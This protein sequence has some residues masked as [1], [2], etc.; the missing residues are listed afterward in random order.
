VVRAV[1][2]AGGRI[3]IAAGLFTY[4][5]GKTRF[6]QARAVPARHPDTSV[7]FGS[8]RLNNAIEFHI[9]RW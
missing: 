4:H 3:S 7:V 8:S 6:R 5:A 1:S 9:P 2:K